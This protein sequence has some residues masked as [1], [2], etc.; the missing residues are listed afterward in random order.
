M[1]DV[2]HP[3]ANQML[4]VLEYKALA[5]ALNYTDANNAPPGRCPVCKRPMRLK[6]GQ[7]K[8]DEHFYHP[9][10]L[11]CPTKDPAARPYLGKRPRSYNQAAVDA[12]RNW[13]AA[14]IE[15]IYSRVA[16]I[17]PCLDLNEFIAILR[18]AKELNIYAYANYQAEHTPYVLVTLINFLRS[19]SYRKTRQLKFMFFFDSGILAYDDLWINKGFGSELVRVSYNK[20]NKT[21]RST[22]ID[23]DVDYAQSAPKYGLSPKQ[24]AWCLREM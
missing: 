16:E 20:N 2:L 14:H 17:A 7:T 18:R 19:T 9:D 24:K 11:F 8:D 15:H 23:I 10:N 6:A 12:N 22:V 5:L 4:T 21:Q 13:V 1:F 3:T